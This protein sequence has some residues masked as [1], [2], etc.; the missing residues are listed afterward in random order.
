MKTGDIV[1]LG[2]HRIAIGSSTDKKLVDKLIGEDKIK[3]VLTDPP[4]GIDYVASKKG[5][6]KLAK[7]DLDIA[8]DHFQ[9]DAEYVQFTKDWI[10]PLLDH[11]EP[12]N[13]FYVFNCDLMYPALRAG[14]EQAGLHYSQ[15]LIWDKVKPTFSRQDYNPQHEVI[16]Y[17]WYK[18]HEFIKAKGRTII[19]VPKPS[20]SKLHPTMKPVPLMRTLIDDA[21]RPG[22]VVFDAFL[23]SGSTLIAC[24]HKNRRCLGVEMEMTYVKTIIARWEKLTGEKHKVL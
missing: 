22:D 16:A 3:Q 14:M 15:Q 12:R 13:T 18:R 11:M 4:Y 1:Q 5:F 6:Q 20:S 7:E 23:G 10:R 9:S 8:N 24:E 21:T 2:D 17:G 19:K